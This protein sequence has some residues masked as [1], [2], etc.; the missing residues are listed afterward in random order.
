MAGGFNPAGA[1]LETH[2]HL[3]LLLAPPLPLL[4]DETGHPQT[5]T[6]LAAPQLQQSTLTTTTQVTEEG[7]V[8][9]AKDRPRFPR[10]YA[11]DSYNQESLGLDTHAKQSACPCTCL[12]VH[13][14]RRAFP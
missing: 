5:P 10:E 11:Y 9:Y 14:C 4:L 1:C 2:M 8:F 6:N 13:V 12:I 3:L 7:Q